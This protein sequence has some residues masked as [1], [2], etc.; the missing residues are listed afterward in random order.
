[1]KHTLTICA[2]CFAL[3]A[4][5]SAFSQPAFLEL[6]IVEAANYNTPLGF[7]TYSEAKKM[8]EVRSDKDT[9]FETDMNK[10][11]T[12]FLSI[13]K[14]AKSYVIQNDAGFYFVLQYDET[15]KNYLVMNNSIGENNKASYFN[16]FEEAKQ[17]MLGLLKVFYNVK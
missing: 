6:T 16:S 3:F 11:L 9:M 7:F 8:Y 5:S 2:F 13:L 14:P 1:M 4:G 10:A 12:L 17:G 15:K